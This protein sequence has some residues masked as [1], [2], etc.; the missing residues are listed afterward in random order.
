VID[1]DFPRLIAAT[2]PNGIAD[3]SYVI[4]LPPLKVV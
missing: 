1:A 4:V 2:V 3:A